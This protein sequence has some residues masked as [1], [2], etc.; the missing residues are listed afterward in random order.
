MSNSTEIQVGGAIALATPDL[1]VIDGKVT[2]TSLQIAEHFGKRHDT[3]LR[4]IRNL[5]V[6]LDDEHRRNFAEVIVEF[7][8]G[9]G[10]TQQGPAFQLTR[11]GFTL[12]AMGFTGKEALLFR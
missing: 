12:L 7:K 2:T 9:K 3:V 4:A 8:N 5:I 11:D 10:G 6:E 1:H